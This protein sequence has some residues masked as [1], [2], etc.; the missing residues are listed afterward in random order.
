VA[1]IECLPLDKAV[2][3]HLGAR[4]AS[5]GIV[6]TRHTYDGDHRCIEFARDIYRADRTAFVVSE[7]LT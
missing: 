6:L 1:R 2:S 5:P 7:K 3:M 4:E